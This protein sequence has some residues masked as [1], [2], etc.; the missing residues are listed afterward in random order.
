VLKAYQGNDLLHGGDHRDY[1][2]TPRVTLE[3]DGID[4]A[5]YADF[6]MAH[7]TNPAGIAIMVTA[8]AARQDTATF[9]KDN[10]D[11][12][13]KAAV[14]VRDLSTDPQ[15]VG[16]VDTLISIENI[17]G[18]DAS[19]VLNI[20]SL[21]G[22][23]LAGA[24]GKGGLRE[25]DLGDNAKGDLTNFAFADI[26]PEYK[27]IVVD[28]KY[29]TGFFADYLQFKIG[30]LTSKGDLLDLHNLNEAAVVDFST[31]TQRISAQAD[32]TRAIALKGIENI[33]GSAF[34]DTI[35]A[36]DNDIVIYGGKGNDVISGGAG[37][38]FLFGG[39]GNDT[40]IGSVDDSIRDL[41]FFF[42]GAGADIFKTY[43]NTITA[44]VI[45]DADADDTIYVND[46]LIQGVFTYSYS[47]IYS[48]SN[49]PNHL[50]H[51][52]D[53]YE[54]EGISIVFDIVENLANIDV[55]KVPGKNYYYYVSVDNFSSG[56]AGII[57]AGKP[58]GLVG[59]ASSAEAMAGIHLVSGPTNSVGQSSSMV[60]ISD[61]LDYDRGY[62]IYAVSHEQSRFFDMNAENADHNF[63][64]N[65]RLETAFL[66]YDL[67]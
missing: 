30:K 54:A 64:E 62:D 15:Y 47:D 24:D 48:N 46:R 13:R 58:A 22:L 57:L 35:T 6:R 4:T 67:M 25:V 32:A 56:I 36:G 61:L 37:I 45:V 14:F 44:D 2:V 65:S 8:N 18:T 43:T 27:A 26:D 10:P 42:G 51:P 1:G 17:I 40:L 5:S 66:P 20:D 55:N 7:K 12:A 11:L 41:D 21:T 28:G 29:Q 31:D 33:V 9:A 50:N 59:P 38:D 19:D 60:G 63:L 53:V 23:K 34:N 16:S 52:Y 39:A 3:D 49:L